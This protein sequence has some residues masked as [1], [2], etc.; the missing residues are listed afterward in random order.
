[1]KK[2]PKCNKTYPKN[3]ATCINCSVKI[4]DEETEKEQFE[5]AKKE[6][7]STCKSET[8]VRHALL[9]TTTDGI[10]GAHIK[11]YFGIVNGT[12]VTGFG[13]LRNFMA[14]FTDTLGGRSG[15]YM[16]EY[17]K[18][19]DM[20]LED[21]ELKSVKLGANAVVGLRL[22]FHNITALDKSFIMV[23]AT[24]TAVEIEKLSEPDKQ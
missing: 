9:F 24:G 21:L 7:A 4:Y 1:M 14:S 18:A 20:A 5:Q 16:N 13:A 2:C 22:E 11:K 3:W 12:I 10:E 8:T 15:S 19:K 6:M 23:T 17:G